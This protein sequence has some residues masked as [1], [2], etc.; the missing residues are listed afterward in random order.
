VFITLEGLNVPA[1]SVS[2]SIDTELAPWIARHSGV[3]ADDVLSCRILKRSL[4]A[5]KKPDVR[6]LYKLEAELRDSARPK[7]PVCARTP[8]AAPFEPQNPHRLSGPVIVGAGPAGLFAAL[9]LALAGAEPVVLERGYDV[10]QRKKD[11]NAF[12][13]TRNLNEDSNF[14]YGEGGAGTW[15]DGK[16]FTRIHDPRMEFVMRTFV[17]CGAPESILYFSH[18]HLGSDRLPGIIAALREKII[19]LGGTFLFGKTVTDIVL[20]N[21]ACR[22]VVLT[23]G[24]KLSAPCVLIA[25]GHSARDLTLSLTRHGIAHRLKGFQI[26]MRIEH[27]QRFINRSQYGVP[28][29]YPALGAADYSL[30]LSP[31]NGDAS[32][33]SATFCMCPGG[34]IIP[35]VCA[36]GT[37]C[38]NGMSLYARSG[39]FAN[40]AVITTLNGSDFASAEAAFD[41]LDRLER[42]AFAAG[43][44]DYTAPAQSASAF[45][46]GETGKL[47]K[48]TS[49]RFG[50]VPAR[51]DELLP[52]SVTAVLRKALARYDRLMPGFV[53][54]GV[55]TG[56][57]SRVSSPVRFERDPATLGTSCP[58]LYS[59]GEGAGMAGGITSAAVDGMRL[60]EAMLFN[61]F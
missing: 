27:F 12:Y 9:T 3:K 26:G 55:F 60:A 20:E 49:Y 53:A 46:K 17:D 61:K 18:P 34:E 25:S 33:G 41:F 4:D 28:E 54:E 45:L 47:P 52:R 42:S 21:G 37:L 2:A 59:G 40:S 29:S 44:G 6:I 14:L 58:G 15:S 30:A 7:V 23:S 11:I 39:H 13:R 51:L 36:R 32:T 24:E 43:G 5:R 48:E 31:V 10:V 56:I 19:S 16:L 50:R 8:D 1:S 57:E 22:G 38:T 35:A